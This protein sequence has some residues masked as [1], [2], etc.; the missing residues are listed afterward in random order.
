VLNAIEAGQTAHYEIT[1]KGIGLNM[2]HFAV[3][4][5][6]MLELSRLSRMVAEPYIRPMCF[7]YVDEFLDTI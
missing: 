7:R 2:K 6:F 1:R 4:R 5:G 3:I